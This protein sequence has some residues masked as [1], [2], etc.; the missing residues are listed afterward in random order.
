VSDETHL[1]Y[2]MLC[3][4]VEWMLPPDGRILKTDTWNECNGCG[5]ISDHET[6]YLEINPDRVSAASAIANV[7]QGDIRAIPHPDTFFDAVLDLST[8]DHIGNPGKAM[9]EYHRVLK[10][11]GLLL[12]ITWLCAKPQGPYGSGSDMQYYFLEPDFYKWLVC[13]KF[14]VI[15]G[16]DFPEHTHTHAWLK[17]YL[18]RALM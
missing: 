11:N 8:N 7:R 15:L 1:K 12:I 10:P 6:H 18:C 2:L 5:F 3:K 16:I 9:L 4:M 13:S 14:I 17:G